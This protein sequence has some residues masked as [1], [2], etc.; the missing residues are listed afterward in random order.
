MHAYKA[1]LV[2][3]A[4]WRTVWLRASYSVSISSRR[5][6]SRETES[7]K[8]FQKNFYGPFWKS[9]ARQ[10]RNYDRVGRAL[11]HIST[12]DVAKYFV[13]TKFRRTTRNLRM[14]NIVYNP[15]IEHR[16]PY[17]IQL[18]WKD[19]MRSASW[20]LWSGNFT[21]TMMFPGFAYEKLRWGDYVAITS[22]TR[23][24]HTLANSF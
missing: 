18:A 17:I 22:R 8:L 3:Y 15:L 2:F 10:S 6:L 7:L 4:T 1:N 16:R 19:W 14:N 24:N 20:F 23:F 13:S 21:Y 9:A 11:K 12:I 5:I